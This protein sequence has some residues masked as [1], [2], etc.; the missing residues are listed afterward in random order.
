M[1]SGPFAQRTKLL[2]KRTARRIIEE[3]AKRGDIAGES[4]VSVV[5]RGGNF[6]QSFKFVWRCT[7]WT[8]IAMSNCCHFT[9]GS[10]PGLTYDFD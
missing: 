6:E 4:S 8:M 5:I 9:V 10:C 1:I 7:T 3:M 2:K